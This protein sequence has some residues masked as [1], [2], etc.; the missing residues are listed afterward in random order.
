M[1]SIGTVVSFPTPLYSN[2]P[3]QSGFYQPNQ[4]IISAITLGPTTIITTTSNLNYVIGQEVRLL[5]PPSFGSIQ[6]NQKKGYVVSLPA[7]NQVEISIDSS[8]NVNPFIASL[9]TVQSAQIMAIG[10]INSGIISTTG[11]N[12]QNVSVTTPGAF[13]NISPE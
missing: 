4:F 10:D 2:V 11:S 3:I 12:L 8:R 13:T 6:L 1:T 9:S 7:S 5:I